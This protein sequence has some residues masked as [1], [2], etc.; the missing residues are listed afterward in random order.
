MTEHI[1]P[2]AQPTV[3][4]KLMAKIRANRQ[5]A[6]DK[7]VEDLW[8]RNGMAGKASRRGYKL[9]ETQAVSRDGVETIEY[10]LYKLVDAAV[11]TISA[12][13]N[14]DIQE[15]VSSAREMR[16]KKAAN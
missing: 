11:V 2:L 5:I 1:E 6:I 3:L 14:T 7:A 12:D 4:G 16:G 8:A 15:G 13:V 9:A 10:R